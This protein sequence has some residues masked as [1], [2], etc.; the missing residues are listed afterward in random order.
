MKVAVPAGTERVHELER[1]FGCTRFGDGHRAVEGDDRGAG[2]T[3]EAA[4]TSRVSPPPP[5]SP[6]EPDRI[7]RRVAADPYREI[8]CPAAFLG[9]AA[10]ARE[11]T[12]A[13]VG[14]PE[15]RAEFA[16]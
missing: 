10:S 4:P 11:L 16:D 12:G 13:L 9:R 15:D 7:G 14:D 2:E 6:A 3:F 8:S 1:P 5:R